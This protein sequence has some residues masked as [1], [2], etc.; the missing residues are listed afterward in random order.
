[1]EFVMNKTSNRSHGTKST[2][3]TA[4]RIREKNNKSRGK[5]QKQRRIIISTAVILVILFTVNGVRLYRRY[6][7]VGKRQLSEQ[8][9]AY[10]DMLESSA[11]RHGLEDYVDYL[12]AI[13]QVESGGQGKDVMQSSESAE[14][15]PNSLDPE[16]SIEQACVYFD[17]LL[18]YKER[19]GVDLDS[20]IQ[21]YNY[22]PS[23]MRYVRDNGGKHTAE[24]ASNYAE[25]KSGGQKKKYNN[26]IAIRANGGWRYAYGNMFYVELVK[27]YL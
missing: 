11:S 5:S 2:A 23:Y 6:I 4:K 22:G 27:Q 20:L 19:Y 1:M 18:G 25:E 17:E 21:S 14:L 13:M 15:P 24:L 26:A 3:Q 10:K 12:L 16:A 7:Y 9:L 8:V